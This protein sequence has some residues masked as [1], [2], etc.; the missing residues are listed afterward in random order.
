MDYTTT[1]TVSVRT[2][3]VRTRHGGILRIDQDCVSV[4]QA[5]ESPDQLVLLKAP[6]KEQIAI[7]DRTPHVV[8]P[9]QF[10]RRVKAEQEIHG[11]SVVGLP[12]NAL[13]VGLID[14]RP[15]ANLGPGTVTPPVVIGARRSWKSRG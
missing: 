3:F 10:V 9:V 6:A 11:A 14:P 7:L 1:R 12:V 8:R 2:N 13:A 15:T 4:A 5:V